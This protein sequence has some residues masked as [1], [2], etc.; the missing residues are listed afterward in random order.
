MAEELIQEEAPLPENFVPTDES[1]EIMSSDGDPVQAQPLVEETD[2]FSGSYLKR[3]KETSDADL[4]RWLNAGVEKKEPPKEEPAA[5][6]KPLVEGAKK[7]R[8]ISHEARKMAMDT[9]FQQENIHDAVIKTEA[10]LEDS[11]EVVSI[12]KPARQAL[13]EMDTRIAKM[14][15]LAKCLQG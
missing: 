13:E 6:E 5:T 8:L 10:V 15:A 14:E 7:P 9:F 12:D 4:L 3:H 2:D 1:L 11:G